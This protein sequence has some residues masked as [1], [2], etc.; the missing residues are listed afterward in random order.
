MLTVAVFLM[1]VAAVLMGAAAN[2]RPEPNKRKTFRRLSL[3]L[4]IGGLALAVVDLYDAV[5]DHSDDP[6]EVV[7]ELAR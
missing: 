2:R 5:E 3:A 6:E 1:L 7:G 4:A